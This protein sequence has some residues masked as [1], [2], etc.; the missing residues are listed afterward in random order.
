MTEGKLL[1]S[2]VPRPHNSR[3]EKVQIRLS[4]IITP[5]RGPPRAHVPYA[6][7]LKRKKKKF[8]KNSHMTMWWLG[9]GVGRKII[10]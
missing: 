9:P 1:I 10:P 6:P 7:V 8:R 5:R 2:G 4:I 3:I